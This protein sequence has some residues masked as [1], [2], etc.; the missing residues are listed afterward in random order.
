MLH[1][2]RRDNLAMAMHMLVETAFWFH[3]V[4]RADTPGAR[5]TAVI[6]SCDYQTMVPFWAVRLASLAMLLEKCQKISS[7][8]LPDHLRELVVGRILL[9]K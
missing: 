8:H 1:V 5:R 4:L 7:L 3:A 9:V 6:R 2:Y